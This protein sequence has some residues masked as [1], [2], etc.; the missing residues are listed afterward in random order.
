ML[1]VITRVATD[2]NNIA[3]L[4]VSTVLASLLILAHLK[5]IINLTM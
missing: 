5:G 3:A 1:R 4:A 2:K